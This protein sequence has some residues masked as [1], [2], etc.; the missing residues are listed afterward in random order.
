MCSKAKLSSTLSYENEE[1]IYKLVE[2]VK[3]RIGSWILSGGSSEDRYVQKQINFVEA[4][5]SRL[6]E[7]KENQE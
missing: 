6:E 3:K 5:T 7:Y 1:V 2:D 4:I